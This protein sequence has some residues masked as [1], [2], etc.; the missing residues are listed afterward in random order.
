M[1]RVST[2]QANLAN[3]QLRRGHDGSSFLPGSTSKCGAVGRWV[4]FIPELV[5]LISE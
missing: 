5:V 1:A 2:Y 3:E 4:G